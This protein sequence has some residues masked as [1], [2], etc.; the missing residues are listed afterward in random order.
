[1]AFL[2]NGN[3]V[4][5]YVKKKDNFVFPKQ[6]LNQVEE[7]SNGGFVLFTFNEAGQPQVFTRCD[8]VA[9]ALALQNQIS[10]WSSALQAYNIEAAVAQFEKG[11][12]EEE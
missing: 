9:M 3:S 10:N 2:F 4:N 12:T 8:N 11:N 6:L 7:C 5:N 1:L